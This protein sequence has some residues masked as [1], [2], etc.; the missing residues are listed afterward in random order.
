MGNPMDRTDSV[1]A[2][3]IL[4][5]AIPMTQREVAELWGISQ[6]GVCAIEQRALR[7]LRDGLEAKG[8]TLADFERAFGYAQ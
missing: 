1:I 7:K 6:R 8:L 3:G 5:D 2:E 4:D